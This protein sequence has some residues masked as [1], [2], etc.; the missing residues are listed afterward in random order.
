V[1]T[2]VSSVED[3]NLPPSAFDAAIGRY[4]LMLLAD[5]TTGLTTVRRS[6][7]A[8]ARAAMAVFAT[9]ERNPLFSVPNDLFRRHAGLAGDDSELFSL[10]RLADPGRLG[11]LFADAGFDDVS[12]VAVQTVTKCRGSR[13]TTAPH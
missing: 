6:L 9:P 11:Q 1:S 12:V 7:R 13:L 4:V 2:L 3:A 10:F 5:P 8:G